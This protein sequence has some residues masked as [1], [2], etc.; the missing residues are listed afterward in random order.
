MTSLANYGLSLI[1]VSPSYPRVLPVMQP[2]NSASGAIAQGSLLQSN[3]IAASSLGGESDR[4]QL[5]TR[6]IQ[7]STLVPL[8][9][10]IPYEFTEPID[11]EHVGPSYQP[12]HPIIQILAQ[13][14]PNLESIEKGL[15]DSPSHPFSPIFPKAFS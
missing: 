13:L 6:S 10:S 14:N 2:S 4:L 15:S 11:E 9:P 1:A 3:A 8:S 5:V 7:P 12:T